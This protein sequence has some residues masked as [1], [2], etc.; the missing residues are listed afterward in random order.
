MFVPLVLTMPAEFAPK[1]IAPYL[2]RTIGLPTHQKQHQ[3][4]ESTFLSYLQ[5]LINFNCTFCRVSC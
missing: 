1:Q 3:E 5:H 4:A 2:L